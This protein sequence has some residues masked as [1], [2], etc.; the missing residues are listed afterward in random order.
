MPSNPPA[1]PYRSAQLSDLYIAL[2]KS[3]FSVK[4]LIESVRMK[5]RCFFIPRH[6]FCIL[7]A[8]VRNSLSPTNHIRP[9]MNQ[10]PKFRTMD[11]FLQTSLSG[12][13]LLA[14]LFLCS[15]IQF[16]SEDIDTVCPYHND[17]VKFEVV[18]PRLKPLN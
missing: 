4:Y 18:Q 16:I 3:P 13:F 10:E 12:I 5:Y 17:S 2:S 9:K 6:I 8:V 11:S 15:L 1:I 7:E 14:I